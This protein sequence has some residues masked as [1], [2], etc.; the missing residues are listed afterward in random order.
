MCNTIDSVSQYILRSFSRCLNDVKV[1]SRHGD[2]NNSVTLCMMIN[3][4]GLNA[5]LKAIPLSAGLP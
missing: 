1:C 3:V 5:G 4:Q 2:V